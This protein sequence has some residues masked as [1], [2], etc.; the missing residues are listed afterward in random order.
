MVRSLAFFGAFNPPSR[1]HIDLAEIAMHE[2]G[3]DHVIF[4]PSK[5]TYILDFQKKEFAFSDRD[6]IEML[7]KIAENRPWMHWTDIEM[8]QETQPRTYDTLCLLRDMGERPALL[9]GADKLP[10]LDHLWQHVEEIA[11]EF[12]IVCAERGDFNC[13][14]MI[15][16]S[17]FLSSLNIQVI[18]VPDQYKDISSTR[19]REALAQLYEIKDVLNSLLPEE[20]A[21]LPADLLRQ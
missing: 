13:E 2:V 4:V 18:H 3:A 14:S 21:N 16:E 7:S 8:K 5:S 1:A 20:L 9:L 15:R 11:E 19:I 12:G 10:E 6:R 17:E